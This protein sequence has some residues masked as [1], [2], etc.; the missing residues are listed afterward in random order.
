M[1]V[2]DTHNEA[3]ENFYYATLHIPSPSLEVYKEST[4]WNRFESIV[5]LTDNETTINDIDLGHSITKDY[6]SLDGM[7]SKSARK[8]FNIIPMSNGKVVKMIR[9]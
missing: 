8:G 6:Y 2:Q 7:K 3:L 5:A 4:S 1:T 9:K